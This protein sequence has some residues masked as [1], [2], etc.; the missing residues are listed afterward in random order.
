M[1][2]NRRMLTYIV[3]ALIVGA[4]LALAVAVASSRSDASGAAAS[5]ASEVSASGV[6]SD[7]GTEAL[8]RRGPRQGAAAARQVHEQGPVH[9]AA[10][11]RCD[12]DGGSHAESDRHIHDGPVDSLGARSRWTARRTTS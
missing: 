12:R 6:Y 7:A 5:G 8:A 10:D 9:P 2:G 11:A 3:I 4:A 1:I